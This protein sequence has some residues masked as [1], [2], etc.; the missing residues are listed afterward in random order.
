MKGSRYSS[1][2][3]DARKTASPKGKQ[4]RKGKGGNEKAGTISWKIRVW[5]QKG[6][7]FLAAYSSVA[8]NSGDA[9]TIEG[10]SSAREAQGGVK[11]SPTGGT[12]NMEIKP[13]YIKKK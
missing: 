7:G 10:R 13:I 6:L 12:H 3:P 5:D 1:R 2:G 11:E 8:R 9:K 4:E